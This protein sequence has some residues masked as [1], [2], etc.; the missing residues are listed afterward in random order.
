[1]KCITVLF[2]ILAYVLL[3]CGFFFVVCFVI[4]F[5]GGGGVRIVLFLKL[6][7]SSALFRVVP[8]IFYH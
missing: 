4:F 1:M 8:T 2:W 3:F 5:L 6:C 7:L